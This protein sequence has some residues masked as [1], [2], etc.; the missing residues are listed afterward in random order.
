ML[1]LNRMKLLL[2]V[3]VGLIAI[4][5]SSVEENKVTLTAEDLFNKGMELYKDE[6][7]LEAQKIFDA[8]KL[9]YPASQFADDAQYYLANCYFNREDYIIAA[10]NFNALRRYYPTSQYYKDAFFKAGLSYYYLAPSFDRDPEY[11]YKAIQALSEF[12]SVYSGDSLSNITNQYIDELRNR[13]AYHDY[14]TANL[15]RK[16]RSP[17]SALIYYNNVISD[18]NDSKYYEDAYL[19]KIEV[20]FEMKKFVELATTID[21]Y[22]SL[23]KSPKYLE[24]VKKI[25]LQIPDEFK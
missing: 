5:C 2:F 17:H 9:Q 10:Y 24:E 11:T 21:L 14:F 13:L 1:I 7:Y 4:S 3:I 20:L 6:N 16:L 15:Y 8:L 22:K 23:F 18:Y 25:E 19:G 12:Q